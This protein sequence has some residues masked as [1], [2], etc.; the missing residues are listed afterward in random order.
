MKNS[1]KLALLS[2]SCGIGISVSSVTVAASGANDQSQQV[3]YIQCGR[4]FN[5][6]LRSL[7]YPRPGVWEICN[8]RHQSCRNN[9]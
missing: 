6:C 8:S 2:L 7:G 4:E 9:C 1:F 3:C 5:N